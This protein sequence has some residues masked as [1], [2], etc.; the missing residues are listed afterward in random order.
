[1]KGPNPQ[2]GAVVSEDRMKRAIQD[3]LIGDKSIM[4]IARETGV[5][6]RTIRRWRDRPEVVNALIDKNPSKLSPKM[7]TDLPVVPVPPSGI[8]A[9]HDAIRM[10]PGASSM[11]WSQIGRTYPPPDMTKDQSALIYMW[12]A[13][14]NPFIV[15]ANRAGYGD[16]EPEVWRSRA[17]EGGRW[18]D[19]YIGL[20][21]AMGAAL[22]RLGQRVQEG[23]A[24]W[25]GAARQ[26][27][28]LR[29]DIYNVKDMNAGIGTSS[30]G[31]MDADSLL[32]VVEVQMR[33]VRKQR[34]A[35]DVSDECLPLEATGMKES[36]DE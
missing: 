2:K 24:G 4:Q 7:K 21:M 19:W 5:S 6:D 15:A 10:P 26:L 12:V 27:I 32:Q 29:P 14:G 16:E 28:A 3:L 17:K 1:M 34:V 8:G 35:A 20:T 30:V 9:T 36:A 25:Q 31:D 18:Q 11:D 23:M 13:R 22:D 33:R